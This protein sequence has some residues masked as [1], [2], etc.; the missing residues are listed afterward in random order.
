MDPECEVDSFRLC[1]FVILDKETKHCWECARIF[2]TVVGAEIGTK[3]VR[4]L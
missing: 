1:E 2:D 4:A 3:M